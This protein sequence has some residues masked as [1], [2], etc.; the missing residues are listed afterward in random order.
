MIVYILAQ[1]PP[2]TLPL[3]VLSK[4]LHSIYV[5]RL[6]NDCFTTLFVVISIMFF[7]LTFKQPSQ[8]KK[9]T[10]LSFG[11]FFYSI[12]TTVKM[13]AILYFPGILIVFFFATNESLIK[14]LILSATIVAINVL[15]AWDFLFTTNV[16]RTHYLE[17][18]FELGRK[19]FFK[20]TV[21][22]RFVPE[23][24]FLSD[25]FAISLLLLQVF[26]LVLF[27]TTRWVS[28]LITKRPF[29]IF[30]L[31]A[32]GISKNKNNQ[33][34]NNLNVPRY[35]L[36]VLTTSNLIGILCAR[37]LHYQ[38]YSWFAWSF[39]FSLYLTNLGP[40]IPVLWLLQEFAW[41][42]F[43]STNLSSGILI[44]SLVVVIGSIWF[45]DSKFLETPQEDITLERKEK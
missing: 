5:L 25:K 36:K 17:K 38:F 10:L 41:N 37:S 7:Q 12:S 23:D 11:T 19:F 42:V 20:W 34:L 21:N 32:L 8:R 39:P 45:S 22:W 26:L 18:S 28:P 40:I 30:V 24:V 16:A 6:F 13:N 29:I 33:C 1:A 4:R 14:T 43:P 15:V 44:S 35:I 27:A 31:N 2:W 3:L 9:L